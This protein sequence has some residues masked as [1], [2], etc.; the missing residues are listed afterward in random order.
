MAT[1]QPP[2]TIN[3]QQNLSKRPHTSP[4]STEIFRPPA[5]KD[6]PELSKEN[7]LNMLK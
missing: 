2:T 3:K 7:L 1:Q 4:S 5:I 6:I